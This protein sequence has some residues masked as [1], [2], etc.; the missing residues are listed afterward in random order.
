MA[1][2]DD[3][4]ADDRHND[5]QCECC[6]YESWLIKEK[7]ERLRDY[8]FEE[9]KNKLKE[10]KQKDKKTWPGQVNKEHKKK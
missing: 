1:H 10:A 7:E 4:N 9:V 2:L 8:N 5:I 6:C 3:R